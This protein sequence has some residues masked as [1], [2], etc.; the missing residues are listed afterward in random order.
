MIWLPMFATVGKSFRRQ[1][2]IRGLK[3]TPAVHQSSQG[4]T[5]IFRLPKR[6]TFL[7][8][9]DSFP[10]GQL[11]KTESPGCQVYRAKSGGQLDHRLCCNPKNDINGGLTFM[12]AV[13]CWVNSSV[14]SVV[15]MFSRYANWCL[16]SLWWSFQ[17][18]NS[19]CKTTFEHLRDRV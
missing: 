7:C 12:K 14:K 19:V 13:S 6:P 2:N 10:S 15:D 1:T 11:R 16:P 8:P 3:L 9:S 18:P 17:L 4:E 5:P